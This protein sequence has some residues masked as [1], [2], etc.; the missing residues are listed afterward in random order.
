LEGGGE[1]AAGRATV[2]TGNEPKGRE[3]PGK[4]SLHLQ[5]GDVLRLETPGGGGCGEK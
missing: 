4:C 2:F 1:G 5:S 3:L